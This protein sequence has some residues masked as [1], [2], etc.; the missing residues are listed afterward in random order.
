MNAL[1][2]LIPLSL[3]LLV[4]ALWAFAWA[5]KRGQFDDLDTPAI[6]ILQDDPT[7][8]RAPANEDDDAG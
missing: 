5:V 1:L 6:D 8:P 4:A 7:P 3:V 2:I